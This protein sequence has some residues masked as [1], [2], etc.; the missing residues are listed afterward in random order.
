MRNWLQLSDSATR[1][2]QTVN[3]SPTYSID[4]E[5]SLVL[6]ETMGFLRFPLAVEFLTTF[7]GIQISSPHGGFHCQ[8]E[9]AAMVFTK[10][11]WD[12]LQSVLPEKLFPLGTTSLSSVFVGPSGKVYLIDDDIFS[13]RTLDGIEEMIEY[14]FGDRTQLSSLPDRVLIE[15]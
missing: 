15:G 4:V 11:Q 5:A 7:Y 14:L 13:M 3:W 10:K 8:P 12:I 9:N 6:I 2:L 1:H